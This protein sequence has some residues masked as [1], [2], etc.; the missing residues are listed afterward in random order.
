MDARGRKYRSRQIR[1]G[2]RIQCEFLVMGRIFNFSSKA[3]PL[4]VGER[5][6]GVKER[7]DGAGEKEEWME[8]REAWEE[9]VEEGSMRGLVEDVIGQNMFVFVGPEAPPPGTS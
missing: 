4:P 7:K 6:E 9:W 3:L 8:E 5:K 2:K 1:T